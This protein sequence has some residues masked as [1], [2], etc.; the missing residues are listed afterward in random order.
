M[1]SVTSQAA[2][3]RDFN[4]SVAAETDLPVKLPYI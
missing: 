1:F 4:S 3:V 2:T